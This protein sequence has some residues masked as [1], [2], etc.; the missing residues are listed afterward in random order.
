M[1]KI[2]TSRQPMRIQLDVKVPMRDGVRLSTDVYLPPSGGPFPALLSRTIY[3]NQQ[4]DRYY[5]WTR[6]VENGYAVVMQDCRGRYDSEGEWQP[7]INEAH[8]GYDTQ[9][10]IGAQPWCDGKVGTFGISYFGFAQTL[11]APLASP[12]LKAM[13]PMASQQDNFGHFYVDGAL[14]LHVALNFMGMAGRTMQRGSQSLLDPI[15][16]CRRLPLITALDDFVDLPFYRDVISHY[17]FDDFWRS[18]SLRDRYG[19]IAVPAYFMTGWY[20]NLLHETF[21]LFQGFK[22][23]GATPET[24]RLTRLLVGPWRHLGIGSPVPIGDIDF[25]MGSAVNVAGEHLRWYDRRL[26]GFENGIDDEPPVRL[27]VMGE[28]VWRGEREWPLARTRFTDYYLH[29][30]G[31][32]NTLHGDGGLDTAPPAGEPP[33]R[34]RYDP[35]DPVPTLGG[36]VGGALLFPDLSGPKDRRPVELRDD[37]LVYTSEPLAAA[38]EVTGPVTMALYASTSAT[39]TAFT[40]TLVD[41]H[42]TGPAIIICDGIRRAR[43]RESIERPS[44]IEP[45]EVYE[46]RIDLWETSNVFKA[47]HRIR[48]EVSSSNFPRYD[49][50]LNTGR[51][52]GLDAEMRIAEQ[53]V[54]HDSAHPSRVTLPVIPRPG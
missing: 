44:L 21:T 39:D 20:D 15:E 45:G 42:P 34:Y 14:Q 6:F 36:P 27:F 2:M 43:F 31:T 12:H 35:A 7:Y 48:V 18:Y 9:Q 30:G 3:D 10:W 50:N 41:V 29:S 8:D 23:R 54:F 22:A 25:G 17:T 51:R 4:Q 38:V 47:G 11:T 32:A 49:R 53:T 26:K 28:N 40:A 16:L 24:R 19:E 5:A 13:V 1:S 52:P 46:Y 33:D 37:V